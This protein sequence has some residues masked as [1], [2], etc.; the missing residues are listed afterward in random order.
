MHEQMK[1]LYEAAK[2]LKRVSG[3]SELARLFNVSPQTIHNW[4]V[5]G[6]S[7]Q[8]M[9]K[10]QEMVGCS[11]LWLETGA[12]HMSLGDFQSVST[13][14]G[15]VNQIPLITAEQAA[16]VSCASRNFSI[17]HKPLNWLFTHV[18]LS[19]RSFAL[20]ITGLAMMPE[21]EKGDWVIVDPAID[22]EPGDFVVAKYGDKANV[23][24][25]K[26]RPKGLDL[27]HNMLFELIPLND[28]YPR[29]RSNIDA[30]EIIGTMAEHRKFR[31][32]QLSGRV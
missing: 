3:Q 9:L 1:R 27:A 21:F 22:P 23:I 4:Q 19:P 31:K 29:I 7:K 20:E 8:G 12:G 13:F 25:R 28:D 18:P 5:R 24:F 30:V 10:A 11:A 32:K 16:R 17:Y 2:V 6:I 14:W 26:Y 15:D